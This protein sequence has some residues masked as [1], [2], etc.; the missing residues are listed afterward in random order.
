MF[1]VLHRDSEKRNVVTK[2][3]GVKCLAEAEAHPFVLSINGDYK[4]FERKDDKWHL[5]KIIFDIQKVEEAKAA[6][7]AG[8]E[9]PGIIWTYGDQYEFAEEDEL[10]K[11]RNLNGTIK[12][13]Y[14]V[15]VWRATSEEVKAFKDA[16]GYSKLG[17]VIGK[18]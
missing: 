3:P 7:K 18:V 2:L 8:K 17:I 9:L 14:V 5:P 11:V 16:I 6:I 12:I 4:I 15:Y 10:V 1:Q 13:G